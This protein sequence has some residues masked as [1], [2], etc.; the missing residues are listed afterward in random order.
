[1]IELFSYRA[2]VAS[3]MVKVVNNQTYTLD[4]ASDAVGILEFSLKSSNVPVGYFV[5]IDGVPTHVMR[6]VS[7]QDLQFLFSASIFSLNSR[8]IKIDI[9]KKV[10]NRAWTKMQ[11]LNFVL[12]KQ[13]STTPPPTEPPPTG[14]GYV[15]PNTTTWSRYANNLILNPAL[16]KFGAAQLPGYNT[17][18]PCIM[19]DKKTNKFHAYFS[20]V[21]IGRDVQVTGHAES[22]DGATNWTLKP[23]FA[24]D[25]GAAGSWDRLSIETCSVH[26]V[27]VSPG[28]FKYFLFYSA[29]NT[30]VG[31]NNDLFK[32]GLA[33]SDNPDS[34]TRISAA[35][36][37]KGIA[38]LLFDVKDAFRA[39][40]TVV[41][42]LVTDPDIVYVNG[43]FKM[44]FFCAGQN[45]AGAYIE[46]GICYATS[47]DGIN[48]TQ[49]GSL[50]TLLNTSTVGVVAQ[51][52]SVIYNDVKKIYE[53][54]LVIDDP[55]YANIGIPGLAV[56]GYYHATSSDGINWI[57]DSKT[58]FDF[59]WN[60]SL[61]YENVGLATGAD[62]LF[63]NN[64]YYMYYPS[65]TTQNVPAGYY[66]SFTWGLNLA[67][68]K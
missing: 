12:K 41:S 31:S 11:T 62:V 40:S 45:S 67:T 3:S 16:F 25:I 10:S 64:T 26:S 24:L 38:G 29:T 4:L 8:A 68:K 15:P 59:T 49:L 20:S 44:W 14:G 60:K 13:S 43:V 9:L 2:G 28:V 1:M 65:F 23:T 35:E 22:S 56:G 58:S 7:G 36:S 21:D 53:M 18:D 39:N 55:A 47:T 30:D 34:F 37:P 46:G 61:A 54:W 50:P 48:W 66:Q 19:F 33:V 5:S 27:E 51:Q 32:I 52:P 42:G 6:K 17:A 63:Y 57:Y